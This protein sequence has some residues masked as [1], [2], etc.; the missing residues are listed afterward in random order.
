MAKRSQKVSLRAIRTYDEL[1]DRFYAAIH[2]GTP[3]N[4]LY[5]KTKDFFSGLAI[6]K[7]VFL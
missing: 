5:F 3:E 1:I 7:R 4:R 2:F 6:A